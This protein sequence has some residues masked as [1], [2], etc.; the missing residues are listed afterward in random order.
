MCLK[1]MRIA[2]SDAL[3]VLCPF[4][5]CAHDLIGKYTLYVMKI[6]SLS[7]LHHKYSPTILPHGNNLISM[8]PT[9]SILM[10]FIFWW[11]GILTQGLML[12]KQS[13]APG[14]NW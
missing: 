3:N 6:N 9:L 14:P 5:I 7:C 10:F 11:Y 1:V 2:S 12:A 4:F 13:H 8:Q